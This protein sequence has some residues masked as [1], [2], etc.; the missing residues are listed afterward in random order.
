MFFK[1]LLMIG[2]CE[3]VAAASLSDMNEHLKSCNRRCGKYLDAASG[4]NDIAKVSWTQW[5]RRATPLYLKLCVEGDVCR[6]FTR[7]QPLRELRSRGQL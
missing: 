1:L 7:L 6:V 5:D 2:V 4:N 3:L